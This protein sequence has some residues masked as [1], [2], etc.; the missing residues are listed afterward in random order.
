MIQQILITV[1]SLSIISL[2]TLLI[3]LRISINRR[4]RTLSQGSKGPSIGFLHPHSLSGGGGE[5]VLWCALNSAKRKSPDSPVVI[6]SAWGD[7]S[8]ALK[9]AREEVK[10]QFGLDITSLSFHAVDVKKWCDLVEP[11]NYPRVTLLLQSLGMVLLGAI[12]YYKHPVDV[13][14]DTANQTFSLILPKLLGART[15]S[16]V[17]YPTISSDMLET[18]KSRESGVNNASDIAGSTWR[19][20]TK[21]LYYHAFARFYRMAGWCTDVALANSSWTM[22]HLQ[23][24]WGRAVPVVFPPCRLDVFEEAPRDEGLIVSVGQFRKEK[25]HD[26]QLDVMELVR[27]RYAALKCHLVM[28]GGVRNDE[29]VSRANELRREAE[30]RDL[31]VDVRVNVTSAELRELLGKASIGIHT[32]RDEHFGISVVELQAAGLVVVAHRSGGVGMD[33]VDDGRNGYLADDV[34]GYGEAIA[35]IVRMGE[36]K[37][38]EVRVNAREG[39][40]R[41][42]ERVFEDG[43]GNAVAKL[44]AR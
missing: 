34:T 21:L 36:T 13:I 24:V 39:C 43:F 19:T 10:K 32:M 27:E 44:V 15:M 11:R 2:V 14:I 16:Y 1:F 31:N 22:T 40:A 8:S 7:T 42:E 28:V 12:A 9:R 41:F 29:D 5:R 30:R 20:Y 35:R 18:V 23:R 4:K 38:D 3:I 6:Y 26:M 25:R 33:I 37:R 17:H